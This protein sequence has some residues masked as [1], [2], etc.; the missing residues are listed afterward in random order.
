MAD[1]RTVR[2]DPS[3]EEKL[4]PEI[5][6]LCDA[7]N[8]AGII[9]TSSCCGHGHSWPHVWFEAEQDDCRIERMARFVLSGE[10]GDH[11]PYFS[12]FWKEV[13]LEGYAWMLE[14]HL[15]HVYGDTPAAEGSKEAVA[16]LGKIAEAVQ[17]WQKSEEGSYARG[18]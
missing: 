13:R 18:C 5:I 7:F 12:C 2:F 15:N 1:W 14:V 3:Y 16:A 17:A 10:Q 4:D 9:T 8:A 11:R 6:P